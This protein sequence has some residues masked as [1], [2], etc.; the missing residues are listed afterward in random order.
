MTSQLL[1]A[2]PSGAIAGVVVLQVAVAVGLVQVD[3]LELGRGRQDDVGV[4]GGV[5]HELL[6]D[7]GEEVVAQQPL[8]DAA[9][10]GAGGDRVG[11]EDV[12]R[13]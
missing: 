6:V 2:S 12:E 13:S 8:D 10:V 4:V 1:L 7:D 11:G 5:G 9:G 3:L